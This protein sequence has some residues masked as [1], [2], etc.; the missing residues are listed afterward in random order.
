MDMNALYRKRPSLP[1]LLLLTV[2]GP[3]LTAC[4]NPPPPTKTAEPVPNVYL[5]A[6]QEAEALK[7]SIEENNLQQQRIDKL[8]D[9]DATPQR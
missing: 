6:V 7:H 2:V 8:L 3:S 5:E 1:S 4:D 9:R